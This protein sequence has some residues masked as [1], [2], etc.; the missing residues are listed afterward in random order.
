MNYTPPFYFFL[1]LV[2]AEDNLSVSVA[3][4]SSSSELIIRSYEKKERE[5]RHSERQM[6]DPAFILLRHHLHAL[7]FF[8]M[9]HLKASVLWAG[10]CEEC[11]CTQFTWMVLRGQLGW[12]L[13]YYSWIWN[14]HVFLRN[15]R[16]VY[17]VSRLINRFD[18]ISP[19]VFCI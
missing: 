12:R 17:I 11:C 15:L 5:P 7:F 4:P 16:H 19:G 10:D 1:L 9:C 6:R 13:C 2:S 18:Y 14:M 3:G 8:L